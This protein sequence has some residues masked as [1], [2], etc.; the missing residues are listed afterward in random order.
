MKWVMETITNIR[1]G[2]WSI[3]KAFVDGCT[4]YV[5]W[6]CQSKPYK[7]VGYYND[8]DEAKDACEKL[9]KGKNYDV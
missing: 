4:L 9:N 8:A 3:S 7:D 1:C 2:D 5:L 6:D